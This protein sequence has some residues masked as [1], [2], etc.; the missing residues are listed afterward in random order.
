MGLI[1][2]GLMGGAGLARSLGAEASS[3]EVSA[4][5]AGDIQWRGSVSAG[6][7]WRGAL[8]RGVQLP[9]E[10]ADF[11]TWDFPLRLSPNRPWRRWS[12]DRTLFAILAVLAEYRAAH[13]EAARVGI[14]DLSR[15]HGGP[16]GRRFGGLGHASHQNGLDADV[17]YPRLD[18]GETAPSKPAQINRALAQDL[19]NRF[20]AAGA[21]YV[22]VGPRT[23]LSGPKKV[24]QR[25]AHHDDHLHVRLFGRG[26]L[27]N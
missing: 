5:E 23:G 15:P 12:A 2:L 17:L 7:P 8:F 25:L 1:P 22:F 9:A 21:R 4:F 19:V 3:T 10:G 26:R 27:G 16:F 14:A 13:P 11:F 18:L 24:V 20:V 6:R